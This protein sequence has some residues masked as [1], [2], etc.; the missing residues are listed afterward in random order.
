MDKL[1]HIR[2]RGSSVRTEVVGGTVTFLS[3]VYILALQ[4]SMMSAAK[5][6]PAAVFTATAISAA[7]ATVVM[8]FIANVPIALASGLGINAFVAFTLCGALG[9]SYQT[10]LTAVLLEGIIFVV[11]SLTGIREA[12]IDALSPNIKKAVGVGIGLFVAL[13]GLANA[14]IVVTG[15]GTLIGLGNVKSGPPLLAVIGLLI[16]I[17]LYARKVKGA[18][19]IGIIAATLIGI[20]LG[21][22][23]LPDGFSPVGIPAAPLWLPFNFGTIASLDFLVVVISMF[24]IDCFDTI[25]TALAVCT[26]AGITDNKEVKMSRIL[27]SDAIGTVIG[28]VF[29]ATTVTSY[30]ESASGCAEG[31]KTGFASLV[32]GGLFLLALV[33][34]PLFLLVPAAATAPA[35]IFVGFLM[36]QQIIG[37]DFKDPTEGIPAFIALLIIPMSYSISEGIAWGVLSYTLV[38]TGTGRLKD[39]SAAGWALFAVFALRLLFFK[40]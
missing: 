21:V 15:G 5:M 12:I 14:K 30:I 4:P 35:L 40:I 34:S 31:A 37:I 8:A 13:I 3:M 27:L 29:G 7:L 23:V 1:F 36:I 28:S 2:E 18:V 9:Y 19:F 33:F 22:T 26:Q 39:V 10:A 25:G 32:T 38:K 17:I 6:P 20:P 16:T 24:C 11:L